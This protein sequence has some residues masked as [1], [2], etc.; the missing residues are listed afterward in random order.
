V[1]LSQARAEIGLLTPSYEAKR[2]IWARVRSPTAGISSGYKPLTEP[3]KA[4]KADA[5]GV[6]VSGGWRGGKSLF[7]GMEGL[8]WLPYAQLIWLIATDYDTTR[9]EFTY[10]AEGAISTG[11]ALPQ[12][13]HMPE[14]R[15]QPCSLKAITGCVVETRTLADFRKALSAKPPDVVIV[16]EPGLID[17]LADVMELLWGRVS[18]KRGCIVLAGTSDEASE[19]WYELWEGWSH[20]NIEGGQSFSLP[21]WQNRYRFPKG[22]KEREFRVYEEKYGH[23]ALMAHYG[24]IPASPADLVLKGYWK[25]AT[26]V[27]PSIEFDPGKPAEIAIDPNYS[28]GNRYTVELIQWEYDS[29]RIYIVDEVAEEGLTHDEIRAICEARPWWRHVISGTIDPYAGESHIYGSLAPVTYWDPPIR[30]RTDH[31]P[32][33]N[34]TV[35]ALKE[36]LAV[37]DHGP[38]T[39]VSPRAKRFIYEAARWRQKSGTPRKTNCDAMKAAGYWFVDH[40]AQERV[41]GGHEEEDNVVVASDWAYDA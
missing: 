23:E 1:P 4:H 8:T 9:Q 29:P 30:L 10:L 39:R 13:V 6:A 34:T 14:A 16:C 11:L 12:N 27:D 17:N 33:V 24:G 36:S 19:E 41:L 40:F 31:R 28:M 37:G 26:H 5:R 2:L 7:S 15:Y 35:Q 3:K 38:R 22:K 20:G 25:Y 21:T 18:E 32:K